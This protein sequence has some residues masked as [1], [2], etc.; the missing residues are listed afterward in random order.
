MSSDF[1]RGL[2][3]V[4]RVRYPQAPWLRVPKLTRWLVAAALS[5][6]AVAATTKDE[7]PAE[8]ASALH[9]LPF[10]RS[11]PLEE[12]GNVPRGAKLSFDKFGRLAVVYDDFY[13]VLNDTTWLDMADRT[14]GGNSMPLVVQGDNG[15][16]Y[17]CS[18]G[19]WGIA[20]ETA[21][22]RLKA[23][24]LAPSDAPK[25]VLTA[26]FNEI[27][28]TKR[29][30]F[31]AGWNGVVY[32]DHA[33]RQNRFFE[34]LGF[35]KMFKVGDEVYV[36]SGTGPLQRIN[37][38]DGT[39]RNIEGT[40]LGEDTVAQATAMDESR[41]LVSTRK[42]RLLIFD[43]TRLTPWSGQEQN[44][45]SGRFTSIQHLPE[46]GVAVAIM[47]KGLFLISAQGEMISALTSTEFQRITQLASR[48]P[49]VLWA[50][51]EDAIQKVLYGSALT[52]FGQRLGLNPSWPAL[53]RWGNRIVVSSG[54]VLYQAIPATDGS[55]SRFEQMKNQ[56]VSGAWAVASNGQHMLVGNGKGAFSAEADG[57]FSPVLPGMDVARLAMIGKD[58]CLAIGRVEI[59][60]IRWTNGRWEECAP[61]IPTVGFP[62]MVHSARRSAWIELG[63]NRVARV[64]LQD[65]V[66]RSEVFDSFPWKEP[67]WVNVGVVDDTVVL[68]GPPG[69]RIFYDEASQ[70]FVPAPQLQRILDQSPAWI[71]RVQKDENGTLWGTHDQGVVTFV[72]KE[73]GYEIDATTFDLNN[74][75][76]PVVQLLPGNDIWLS[77]G[78][79][80]YHVDQPKPEGNPKPAKRGQAAAPI[81][82]SVTDE[83]TSTELITDTPSQSAPLRLSY[84]NNNLGFRFFSGGYAWRRTPAYEFRI[85][86]GQAV[87]TSLGTGSLLSFPS[88]H[89]GSYRLSVRISNAQGATNPA[90]TL[91]FEILPPWYRTWP[92]YTLY[93]LVAALVIFGLIEW[94]VSRARR[95]NL[96]LEGVVRERTDQL[97]ATMQ[98]LN[99]ETRNAATLAERGRLAGEIHDS[100]QQ[101]LS[102]LM[103]Q[104]DATL[105][106]PAIT[107][108]VRSR[109]NVAR[110]MIS[111]T[112]HEVQH[113]V[114]DKE[115]PLLEGAG[116]DEALRKMSTLIGSGAAQITV[117]VSGAPFTIPSAPQHHLLRIAQEAIT[118]AVRHAG[119]TTIHV[120]LEYM[121][122]AVLLSVSDKGIGFEPREVMGNSIGHFGLRGLRGRAAKIGGE[123]RV[124]SSSGSGTLIE[125]IVPL[126]EQTN[127]S[128][129]AA[130]HT[131]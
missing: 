18:F 14:S 62:S 108:D 111:F 79:S 41:T 100:L 24:S 127:P 46:G 85:S 102:G 48:E 69:T 36:S 129:N 123:L 35:S 49:G 9:G 13:S 30:V 105:K 116:L 20:E 112:R 101:G 52:V 19:S 80:L 47:G 25:W 72:P 27:I 128:E 42:G 37:V 110:N 40:T 53:V 23:H 104:L 109:L 38:G 76:Y 57:S 17:Y 43:G 64:S 106:L 84:S 88:L 125:V 131:A 6:H 26:G 75:H 21:G 120:R 61:R 56:P 1:I 12:I 126:S 98:K 55:S 10:T 92:S 95:H 15:E 91:Q 118:N 59:A 60:A 74:E 97:K 11:Y 71:V 5:A 77:T 90:A 51:G 73:S 3:L 94:S 16:A 28:V 89:E 31:F 130:A 119:P 78:Q 8:V 121:D 68:S 54:G 107:G 83:R 7:P 117:S 34:I 29:G 65:R 50:A 99:E 45:L 87:W 63:V 70:S 114:W 103:L 81:L 122:N 113:A 86:G 32:W 4:A 2:S 58:V 33:T 124:E 82:V 44:S 93:T 67:R 39:F 66:L 22:G 115:S 96:A